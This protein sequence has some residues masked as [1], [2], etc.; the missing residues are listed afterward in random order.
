VTDYIIHC[1][2]VHRWQVAAVWDLPG[3]EPGTIEVLELAPCPV[4]RTTRSRVREV[5]T[6]QGEAVQP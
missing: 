3:E 2:R 1:H 6:V 5:V 4:C